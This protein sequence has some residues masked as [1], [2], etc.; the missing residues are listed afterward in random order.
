MKKILLNFKKIQ[1]TSHNIRS[2]DDHMTATI[3]LDITFDGTTYSDCTAN[4]KQ[5]IG[6]NYES[7]PL[8]ISKVEGYKGPINRQN[9]AF[10]VQDL[11]FNLVGSQGGAI[12]VGKDASNVEM[13]NISFMINRTYEMSVK[14]EE[15]IS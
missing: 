11:Y 4:I 8:E 6:S 5:I 3:I 14:D 13:K 10:I 12:R 15:T 9:F 7:E 1:Q 2:D